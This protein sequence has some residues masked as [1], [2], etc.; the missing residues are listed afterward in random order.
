MRFIAKLLLIS[1]VNT[2]FYRAAAGAVAKPEVPFSAHI[3]YDLFAEL[4]YN[5]HVQNEAHFQHDH[6]QVCLSEHFR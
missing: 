3:Y 5:V 1:G 4:Q 2:R 6:A